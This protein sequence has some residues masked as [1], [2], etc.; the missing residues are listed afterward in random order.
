MGKGFVNYQTLTEEPAGAGRPNRS[1]RTRI[2]EYGLHK[3]LTLY[4]QILD[5]GCNRGYFGILLAPLVRSYLGVEE[6]AG[7]L[8]HGIH[9]AMQKGF[10]NVS[11]M[12][13]SFES[14]QASKGAFTDIFSFAVHAYIDLSMFAYAKKMHDM[15]N[16]GGRIYLE[17]HP[18]DYLGEPKK[19]NRLIEILE[20]QF[21]M[22][23][24][25]EKEVRDRANIRK[26]FVWKK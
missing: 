5:I 8:K 4:S 6:D 18:N 19:L 21:K 24:E 22:T 12:H 23:K 26:F 9:E 20:V 1:I 13:T 14:L 7:Q 16:D 17:G 3:Y 15:L 10:H 2:Q 25:E 11:F